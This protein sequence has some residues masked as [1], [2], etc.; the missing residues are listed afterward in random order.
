VLLVGID[1]ADAE[2]V[3]CLMDGPGA[4][5]ATGT[6]DHTADGLERI[7]ALVRARTQDPADVLVAPEAVR[8]RQHTTL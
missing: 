8:V 1:W 2:H 4:A 6:I 5:L 7:M 3:Y